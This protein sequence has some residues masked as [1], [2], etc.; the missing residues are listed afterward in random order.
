MS[1]VRF[2]CENCGNRLEIEEDLIG[3]Q[4]RCPECDEAVEVPASADPEPDSGTEEP[5]EAPVLGEQP[6]D[7]DEEASYGESWSDRDGEEA[8]RTDAPGQ[9]AAQEPSPGDGG[10]DRTPA[11]DTPSGARGR[12]KRRARQTEQFGVT[13]VLS[14]SFSVLF[15]NFLSFMSL[16]GIVFSPYI[17]ICVLL[18]I[19]SPGPQTTMQ[20]WG[21]S[22]AGLGLF[23][24]PLLSAA[25]I[26]GVFRRLQGKEFNIPDCF[27]KGLSKILPLI[28]LSLI[29]GLLI[30]GGI[31]LLVV[32]GLIVMTMLYVSIP[33]LV[34][35]DKGVTASLTRSRRLT[36]GYR[37]PTFGIILLVG[38]LTWIMAN[39]I[40]GLLLGAVS[41]VEIAR[42]GSGS[43]NLYILISMFTSVLTSSFTAIVI[44]CTYYFLRIDKESASIDEIVELFD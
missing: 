1:D 18:I 38:I 17:L 44:V 34:L 21:F 7:S 27:A 11:Q 10:A 8:G 9:T 13:N 16:G 36:S 42:Q 25:L 3:E 26:Y 19:G 32:P 2:D 28:G 43:L 24:T 37:W 15:D 41:I 14:T 4:V 20:I 29:Q 6:G 5:E 33:V 40:P 23:L 22:Q 35:E 31:L 12:K 39:G 30:F